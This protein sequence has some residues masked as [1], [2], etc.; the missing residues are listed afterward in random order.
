MNLMANRSNSMSWSLRLA[1][2]ASLFALVAAPAAA[3][4]MMTDQSVSDAVEDEILIDTMVP[5]NAIDVSSADGVVTLT[6][7]VDNLLAK[8]RAERIAETVKGVRA[9][10]NR[11]DLEPTSL[12]SDPEIRSDVTQALLTDPAT[13]SYEVGVNVANGLVTLTGQVDSWQES[14]LAERVAKGV[15]GVLAVDNELDWSYETERPDH[16]LSNEI[17]ARLQWDVLV[18]DGLI[19]VRVEDG[20]V[21]LVGTVGSAAEKRE[22]EMDAWVPGVESVDVSRLEV[23]RWARDEDLRK[24]KYVVKS[25]DEIR[26]AVEDALLF[27]PRVN[28]FDV[29]TEVY[30]GV[31]T[32]RGQVDNLKAKRA[33]DHDARNTVGV[34]DVKSRIR[35]RPGDGFLDRDVAESVRKALDRDPYVEDYEI[36]VSVDNGVVD[37]YGTVDT[38]FEKAH[39]DDVVSRV[40][41]VT[42]VDNN[43]VVEDEYDPIAYDPYVE[44][45]YLYDYD[46]YDYQPSNT[47]VSDAEIQRE[48]NDE[49]FWSPFVDGDEVRVTV[50]NGIA[51]L[52]G[53]VDTW[54]ERSAATE[55]AF[56]GG[57]TW[58]D[59][60][61]EVQ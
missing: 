45:W 58:V 18:D 21:S 27:D 25:D 22:A 59:N 47:L 1:V 2:F 37:L 19:T 39:A 51:T 56:E 17:K 11:I 29:K 53:T 50:N 13:D 52:T 38:Y 15:S 30:G 16:E 10:V 4:R 8:E 36:T 9:V 49:L 20:D 40:N 41:G 43:L 46:W 12:R 24:D 32:L 3:K 61:L 48:I 44:D 7:T 57:A 34:V 5:Y 54:S 14:R 42:I 55:N 31:V 60:D 35:V 33:A 23:R 6:G 26:D 28:S